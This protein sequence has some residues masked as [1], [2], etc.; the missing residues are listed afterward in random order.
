[1]DTTDDTLSIDS[2]EPLNDNIASITVVDEEDALLWDALQMDDSD[3]GRQVSV[4]SSL[5]SQSQYASPSPLTVETAS[6]QTMQEN[7]TL[8]DNNSSTASSRYTLTGRPSISLY[9]SCDSMVLSPYQTCIRRHLELFEACP[10][11]VEGTTQGRN[12]PIVLGQVGLRCVHCRDLPPRQR[13]RGAVY[14]PSKLEGLYQAGQNMA[15]THLCETCPNIPA[16]CKKDLLYYKEQKEIAGGGKAHWGSV[17]ANMGVYQEECGLRFRPR[18]YDGG[19]IYMESQ[20]QVM[21]Y[22]TRKYEV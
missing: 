16:E 4:N 19:P 6:P 11:E 5:Q 3:Q 17:A 2:L 21:Q 14:Y 22:Y 15:T 8:I 12:K 10:R 13:T 7:T 1:M 9:V 18:L 20:T